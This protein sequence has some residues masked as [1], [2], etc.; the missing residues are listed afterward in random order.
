MSFEHALARRLVRL[1]SLVPILATT[2]GCPTVVEYPD[3]ASP[4]AVIADP[5]LAH[6]ADVVRF[7]GHYV[8]A[9]LYG[10]RL[11]VFDDL[12]L[13]D[14]RYFDPA[15]IGQ[16]F[17]A[18]HYLA[19][20]PW[21]TLLISNGW[22]TSIV[23]IADLDG[24]GWKEFSGVGRSFRAPHGICVDESGLIYVA[25]SLNSRL[26]R[27]SDLD[28]SDWQ[29]FD[30]V[31]RQVSYVRELVCEAGAVWLANSYEGRPGLNPG[32]GSNILR[33]T[34]FNSGAAESVFEFA[35]VNITAALPLDR[36]TILV[37]LWGT[38]RRLALVDTGQ[39]SA[40][41]RDRLHIGVPY[42]TY[43]DRTA[44]EILVAHFG[45]LSSEPGFNRGGIAVY[46]W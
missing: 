18:P 44:R 23:E 5:G 4:S 29:V 12:D 36:T 28:G 24:S 15:S 9:E 3:F 41:L 25:D 31:D 32:R 10:N 42:G 27:F 6:P 46:R 38:Q 13:A 43:L 26:V 34:D 22:G 11:A 39:S 35:D 16:K 19:V 7:K 40:H 2:A 37:G 21:D 17:K 20:T 33:I 14:L 45:R 8:A 30:D 1:L